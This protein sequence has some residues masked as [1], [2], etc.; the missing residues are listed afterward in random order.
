[1]KGTLRLLTAILSCVLVA[2]TANAQEWSRFRGP[3]GSGVSDAKTIPSEWTKTDFNWSVKLPGSGHSSPVLWG[4]KIFLT[5]A[6]DQESAKRFVFCVDADTGK[7]LWNKNF[8]SKHHTKHAFNS[9][10]SA[11]AA[12]DAKH[13][14]VVWS[15]PEEYTFMAIDH[16]GNKVWERDL[17][18]FISQHSCGTS[19]I[20]YEDLIVL[21]NDQDTDGGGQSFLLAVD[22]ATGQTRWKTDRE[23]T[24]VAYST[25][26]IY[27]GKD[28]ADQLIFNSMSHGMTSIDPKTGKTLWEISAVDG[29]PLLDKRSCSSPVLADGVITASCGSGGGGN[30]VVAI[31]PGTAGKLDSAEMI[32]KIDRSAPYVCTPLAKDNLLFL[33]SDGGVVSCLEAS[34]GDV[35][36]RKRVEGKYFGSPVWVDGRLFCVSTE[37][38]VVVLDA[39]TEFK[40]LAENDLDELCHSTP[41]VADGR[42]FIRTYDH[43][44]SIGGSSK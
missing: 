7:V 17:G 34:T 20:V 10:A 21:T 18:P 32:Y 36:W 15:T 31:R 25:P 24:R 2:G 43:L 29:A 6:D 26:C 11:T 39:G 3:N 44:H 35:H 41:A 27:Q 33:W 22:A 12:A 5:G 23:S 4:K 28:G 13:V 8:P 9:F 30:Y 37:G 1:M 40:Q 14:Y 16:E 38:V 42:M 19:P